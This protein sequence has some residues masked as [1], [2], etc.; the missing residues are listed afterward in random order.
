MILISL[1]M[2]GFMLNEDEIRNWKEN[3]LERKEAIKDEEGRKY[4]L[5]AI[6]MLDGVLN[7]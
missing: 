5:I 7:D 4:C 2:N 3:E 1:E 6:G